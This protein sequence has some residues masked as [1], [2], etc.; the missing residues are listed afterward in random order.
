MQPTSSGLPPREIKKLQFGL[1][2]RQTVLNGVEKGYQAVSS[3]YGASGQNVLQGMPFGDP[4]LTRD[5]VTVAK[6]VVLEDR[7]ENDAWS[8]IRQASEKTN[9]T[10]GDG[11]TAT[12][13]LA[14]NLYVAAHQRVVAGENPMRLKAQMVADSRKVIDFIKSKS[15]DAKKHLLEVAT[16]SSGDKNIGA[17]VSDTIA[18]IGLDGGI[19]IREQS[20]PTV[21][22]EKINGYYFNKGFFALNNQIEWEKPHILVTQKPLTAAADI[23]PLIKFI[24]QQAD[25]KLVIIGDV[26]GDA[27]NLL[28]ANTMAQADQNGNPVPF[29]GIVIPPPAYND[30]AKLYMEDIAIYTGAKVY[31]EA[32][33]NFTPEHFGTAERIQVN[34]DRAI[35]FKGGGDGDTITSRAAEIKSNID[36]EVDAHVKDAL[37]QRYSKLVGK[38]AIV[39]VGAST[40]TEM[41]ELK[42]RVEDAIE[43]TKSAMADGVVP[44]GATVLAHAGAS[45]ANGVVGLTDVSDLFK[46]ALKETFKKLYD[47]AGESPDYRLKQIQA[48]KFGYGFNLREM[49][50]EPVDLAKAGIWDATRAVIQ[51]IENATSA[52]GALLTV[53]ALVTPL[54]ETN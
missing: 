19:T 52:A 38:I 54:D 44:G 28:M 43:A 15:V 31:N 6:R 45:G 46:T 35:I 34:Q 20:Y 9:K 24:N 7:A 10:A 47:N 16:V 13:V 29:E 3:T 26:R 30:E 22:V 51:T 33:T 1:E 50:E 39:N 36:K 49:T 40:P 23:L 25:K 14:R 27:L 8:V 18:D 37:E 32:E 53:G 5:G 41:E 48:A 2:A 17:L 4:V 21:D 42:F 12:V 11:T